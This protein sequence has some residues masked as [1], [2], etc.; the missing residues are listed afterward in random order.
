[1]LL[2]QT[3][4][5]GFCVLQTTLMSFSALQGKK[6]LKTVKNIRFAF[7]LSHYTDYCNFNSVYLCGLFKNKNN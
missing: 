2:K 6:N 7:R 1:M 4:K 5:Q 3:N